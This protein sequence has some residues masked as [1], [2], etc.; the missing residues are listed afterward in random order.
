MLAGGEIQILK[1]CNMEPY[2]FQGGSII[3][4]EGQEV[5]FS[6]L[7]LFVNF[8]FN[9]SLSIQGEGNKRAGKGLF[10]GPTLQSQMFISYKSPLNEIC[11]KGVS[12]P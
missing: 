1:I 9:T 5:Y 4:G 11:W 12:H 6:S 7:L 8:I 10:Q 2:I 3:S